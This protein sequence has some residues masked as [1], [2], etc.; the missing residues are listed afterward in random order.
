MTWLNKNKIKEIM[1]E[2]VRQPSIT[3]TEQ[4]MLIADSICSLIRRIDYFKKKPGNV[5]RKKLKDDDLGR[6][7]VAAFL[8]KGEEYKDTIILLNH[9]DVVDADDFG[10]DKNLA[11]KPLQYT[12]KIMQGELSLPAQV[13][14]DLAAGEYIFGRGVADMK[15]GLAVHLALLQHYSQNLA[16][17]HGN[18]LFLSVPDEE[19]SSLGA[20]NS[21]ELLAELRNE[22]SLNYRAVIN[23]EPIAP[24]Y[25][26][27]NNKYI[28]TGSAGKCVAFFYCVGKET[29]ATDVFAGL[30]S[31]LLGSRIVYLLEGNPDFCE[32]MEGLVTSP[33]SC[34]KLTDHKKSYSAKTPAATVCYFN[35]PI[36]QSSAREIMDKLLALGD[37]AFADVAGIVRDQEKRFLQLGQRVDQAGGSN[38]EKVVY[39]Y[40]QFYAGVYQEIGEKL[41]EEIRKVY[42]KHKG[43]AQPQ[44][45]ALKIVERMQEISRDKRPKI[46]VGFLPPYYPSV[47]NEEDTPAEKRLRDVAQE[48]IAS[49]AERFNEKLSLSSSYLGISDLS[50]YKLGDFQGVITHLKPN[51]PGWGLAYDLP[52]KQ[53]NELNI[54]VLNLGVFGRDSH[55]RFERVEEKFSFEILPQLLQS[56]IEKLLNN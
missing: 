20:V 36:L 37:Q 11:F 9:H 1:L 54:P 35:I 33:P 43:R 10:E 13:K 15:S 30:N 16:D 45:L 18:I 29:H 52:L 50:Y 32:E 51:M 2:L 28:Y 23:S 24:N 5:I 27:D 7:I 49:A 31:N 53:I 25:P 34:L 14:E 12:E 40:K 38:L 41:D 4:E 55:R 48:V 6:E 8:E 22:K 56:T 21:I 19:A 47:Y 46:I 3:R 26:G 42:D 17:L 39:S 44:D